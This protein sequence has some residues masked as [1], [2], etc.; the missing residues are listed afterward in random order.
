[1]TETLTVA[2]EVLRASVDDRTVAYK[3]LPYGVP[4]GTSKGRVTASKGCLTLPEDPST[5]QL[6]DRHIGDRILASGQTLAWEDDALVASFHVND[7]PAG[8]DLLD[9]VA[10]ATSGENVTGIELRAS[11][12]VEVTNPVIRGGKLLGGLLSAVGAV[13]RPAFAGSTLLASDVGE[14]PQA[15]TTTN[16]VIDGVEYVLQEDGSYIPKTDPEAPSVADAALAAET[17]NDMGNTLTASAAAAAGVI[18]TAKDKKGPAS[19]GQFS[20]ALA[21]AFATG[22][23]A[24]MYAALTDIVHDDGDNDGDGLGE[25]ASPSGWLGNVFENAPYERQF[26]PLLAQGQLTSYRENGFRWGTTPTVAA[27]TG[28]KAAVPSTGLT[29]T[30]VNYGTQRWANAADIDRRYVDFGDSDVIQ[31]F[32]EFNVDS[33]KEVTDLDTAAKIFANASAGT[34]A[35]VAGVNPAISGLVKLTLQLLAARFKP[36]F[37]IVGL[38]V[39][40]PLLYLK[41]DDVSAFL[42]E[43]FGLQGGVFDNFT[44]L[45]TSIAAYQNQVV[46]GD[47]RTMRY[48]ELGGTPVRVE[49][50]HIANGGRDIGVFGYSSFQLLKPGG[51]LK[52]DVIP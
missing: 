16:V 38:D 6:N 34:W 22:G 14:L 12:S 17:E 2:A 13:V 5:L 36:S 47:G 42:T 25:L 41:K 33:Y 24:K 1:M 19:I 15:E 48:K 28:N 35:A 11:A 27:Y 44:I 39:Y 26:I 37:A 9:E 52:A 21:N 46:V 7:G 8:D 23:E 4:G 50:E 40:E 43:S 3:I 20:R 49:A 51:V 29:A 10:R 31:S 45:P 30:P 18:P 32:I